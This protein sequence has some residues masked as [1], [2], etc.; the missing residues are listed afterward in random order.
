MVR[1]SRTC[2]EGD[3]SNLPTKVGSLIHWPTSIVVAEM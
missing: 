3:Q 2:L 1:V